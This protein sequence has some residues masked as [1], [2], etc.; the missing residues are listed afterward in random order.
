MRVF[1]SEKTIRCDNV[2]LVTSQQ[3][4]KE[5]FTSVYSA[6]QPRDDS[7]IKS[8]DRIDHCK[9]PGTIAAAVYSDHQFARLLDEPDKGEEIPFRM[10]RVA[11]E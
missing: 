8:I 2:I 5:L 1:S 6:W 11:V 4:N 9:V 7:N 10:K 3:Q